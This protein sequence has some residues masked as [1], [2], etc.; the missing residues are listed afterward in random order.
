M[1]KSVV[2]VEDVAEQR[3]YSADIGTHSVPCPCGDCQEERATL[4]LTREEYHIVLESLRAAEERYSDHADD[5]AECVRQNRYSPEL[6]DDPDYWL[7]RSAA[8]RVLADRVR[9]LP[10]PREGGSNG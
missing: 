7:R 4:A 8:C 2:A 9:Q 1:F 10:L 5:A 6:G 3:A